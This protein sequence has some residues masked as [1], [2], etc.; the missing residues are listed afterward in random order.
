MKPK[1]LLLLAN[2]ALL[3]AALG[4]GGVVLARRAL[5]TARLHSGAY[6]PSC[7]TDRAVVPAAGRAA[8]EP[9]RTPPQRRPLRVAVRRWRS[10]GVPPATTSP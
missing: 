7:G 5:G 4:K 6:A 3:A 9:T 8:A 1:L 10:S 2:L